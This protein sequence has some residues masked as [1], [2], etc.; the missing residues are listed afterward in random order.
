[1][2]T[3]SAAFNRVR[4]SPRV[5]EEPGFSPASRTIASGAL[6]PVVPT[7]RMRGSSRRW[8]RPGAT[9]EELPFKGRVKSQRKENNSALPNSV[10]EG[11]SPQAT[12]VTTN[13]DVF[14]VFAKA[15]QRLPEIHIPNNNP[16]T[17]SQESKR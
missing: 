16:N 4:D 11:Q 14:R 12:G 5:V 9:V 3:F 1:V 2:H 17:R 7:Q 10:A 8:W 15:G 6:G 13:P